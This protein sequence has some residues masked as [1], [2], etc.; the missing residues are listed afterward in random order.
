[1][2]VKTYLRQHNSLTGNSKWKYTY[3][4]QFLVDQYHSGVLQ[5]M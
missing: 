4:E 2:T 5:E 3:S 1:M